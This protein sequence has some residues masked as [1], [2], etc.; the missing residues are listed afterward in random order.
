M[1]TAVNAFEGNIFFICDKNESLTISAVGSL[2]PCLSSSVQKTAMF[3]I[4]S[5][6]T[7][8]RHGYVV[9]KDLGSVPTSLKKSWLIILSLGADEFIISDNSF[10]KGGDS[11]RAMELVAT[12]RHSGVH[13]SVAKIFKN[14]V[15]KEREE[16]VPTTPLQVE[17]MVSSQ[18]KSG[19]NMLPRAFLKINSGNC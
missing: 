18:I 12:A 7:P 2:L 15:F 14:P 5:S 8:N 4:S 19:I 6:I 1:R 9:K 17:F 11:I 13:V 10:S 3:D 16:I